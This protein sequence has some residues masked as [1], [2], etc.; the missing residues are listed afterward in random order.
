VVRS[1][2]Y[3]QADARKDTFRNPAGAAFKVQNLRS[4]ETGKG[5]SNV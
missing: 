3:H 5:L 1:L 2:P 4:I